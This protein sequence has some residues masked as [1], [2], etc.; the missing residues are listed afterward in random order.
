M[1]ISV[2]AGAWAS[3]LFFD[4]IAF[5]MLLRRLIP[6]AKTTRIRG[7]LSDVMLQDGM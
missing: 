2:C 3:T 5:A 7:G 6:Q 4:L 1:Y